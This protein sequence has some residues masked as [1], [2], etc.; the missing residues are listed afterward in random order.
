MSQFTHLHVASAFSG[1]YGVT[2][3]ELLAEAALA[4]GSDALAV[5][6]RD[7]LYGAV[8]HIGACISLGISPIV[9]VSLEVVDDSDEPLARVIVLARGRDAGIGWAT[10]CAIVSAAHGY[11]VAN[12]DD[13]GKK[14]A[15][16]KSERI[17]IRRGDLARIIAESLGACT[18]LIGNDSD[19]GRSVLSGS[20]DEAMQLLQPWQVRH[21]FATPTQSLRRQTSVPL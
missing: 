9:G 11:D 20:R 7:G 17:A 12:V 16:S 1:H 19:V 3:P 18:V 15:R 13:R 10:L 5:T 2:R 14:L 6:D 8:K 21:E 4:Q